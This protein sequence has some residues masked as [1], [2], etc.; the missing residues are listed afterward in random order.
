MEKLHNSLT[1]LSFYKERFE[2][3]L[4]LV[5]CS[6]S[7]TRRFGKRIKDL[8]YFNNDLKTT[9]FSKQIL[10]I[11]SFLDEFDIF[12][13]LAKNN[14]RIR[15]L[16]KRAKPVLNRIKEVKGLR[17]Y[18]NVMVAHNFRLDNELDKVIKLSDFTKNNDYPNSI[19]EVFFIS[20]LC[21]TLIELIFEEFN[22]EL[23]LALKIYYSHLEDDKDTP[24]RGVKNLREAYDQVDM[25]RLKIGMKPKFLAAEI[26]EFKDALSRIN[27]SNISVE[28]N[29]SCD[30]TNKNWCEVLSKYL[31]MR[32]YSNIEFIQAKKGPYVEH[33]ICVYGIIVTI[34]ERLYIYE[35]DSILENFNIITN[36][37]PSNE[38]KH[39]ESI[40]NAYDE[41]MKFVTP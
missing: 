9:I 15:S 17:K 12:N 23:E 34:I 7:A 40:Q 10:D 35:E 14:E 33:F 38:K 41:I 19:A 32:G 6:V 18:R 8:Y 30:K 11:C 31:K 13:S 26:I 21:L 37:I 25:Y 2:R 36:W 29:L 3:D 27:F 5:E 1:V 22:D 16:C 4:Y 24:L 28:F 39:M 20:C